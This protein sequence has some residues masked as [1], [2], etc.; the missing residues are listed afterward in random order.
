[1]RKLPPLN[2]LRVFE[3]AALHLSFSKAAAIL[4][5]T[6]GAVSK[7]VKLLEEFLG[8]SLFNRHH[9]SLSLTKEGRQ[10]LA[11]ISKSL[12]VIE[13]ATN[14][15]K[16]KYSSNEVLRINV[17]PTLSSRWLVPMLEDFH[18]KYPHIDIHMDSGDGEVNLTR[19]GADIAIRSARKPGWG[20]Y[21][22]AK[23]MGENLRPVMSNSL[24]ELKPVKQKADLAKHK[25]LKHTTRPE[26]WP[27]Y[28]KAIGAG[29]L[30][31]K[32]GAGFEHFF[33]LVQAVKDNMGIALLPEFL[34]KKELAKKELVV[35]LKA[36]FTSPYSY[37][38][39]CSKTAMG[40][41]KVAV[42]YKWLLD[43]IAENVI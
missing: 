42:F 38:F 11:A 9:Q 34:I 29:S 12:D 3:V 40:E 5:V 19:Q 7:Q 26:M 16:E 24:N 17:L 15:A 21:Y 18:K 4:H 23:I 8:F 27:E 6:Q 39:I 13:G 14:L 28:L 41:R 32:Y 31:V 25:L 33:M 35:A 30:E 36:K 37:Y 20:K 22:S 2:S 10:Y 1:M 43:K